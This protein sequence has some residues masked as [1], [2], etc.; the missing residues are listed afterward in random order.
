MSIPGKCLENLVTERLNYFLETNGQISPLQFGFTAGRS[1]VDAIKTVSEF[2]GHSRKCGLK[3]CL[4]AL[5]I[6][7]GHSTMPGTQ[8]F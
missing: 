3:R 1:T 6:G 7:G 5:D 8:E 2:V 4:L